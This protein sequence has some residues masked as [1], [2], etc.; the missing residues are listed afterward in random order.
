M[1]II[2][3]LRTCREIIAEAYELRRVL[4]LRYP[5]VAME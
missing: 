4:M 1:L 5:F 2:T 3:A